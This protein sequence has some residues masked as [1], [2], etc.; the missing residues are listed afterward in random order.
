MHMA[1]VRG[2]PP[3]E[4]TPA[5][6]AGRPAGTQQPHRGRPR[7]PVHQQLRAETWLPCHQRDGN[8]NGELC[9]FCRTYIVICP[10]RHTIQ[11]TSPSYSVLGSAVIRIGPLHFVTE[12]RIWL[13]HLTR[14]NPSPYDLYCVGGTL[15]LTQSI[16]QSYK[17]LNQGF[18]SFMFVIGQVFVFVFLCF[19]CTCYSFYLFLVV[20]ISAI[21]C[22][23]RLVS[24]VTCYASSWMYKSPLA[25]A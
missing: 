1:G 15:S 16:N 5:W 25:D 3:S 9:G 23:E 19:R 24:E 6:Q 11:Y 17:V 21:N 20:I 7:H 4:P 8:G 14:K 2:R 18:C 13:G 12:Y 22:L 10:I